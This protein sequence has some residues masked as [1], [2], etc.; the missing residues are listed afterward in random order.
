MLRFIHDISAA[1]IT[2]LDV[3]LADY[4][5]RARRPGL[6]LIVSDMFSYEGRYL[7][8]LNALLSRGHEV[9][10]AHV[11]APGGSAAA[12]ERRPQPD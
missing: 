9:A 2:D 8:G 5:L 1:G 10:F 4:A 6:T 11:L 12:G 3:A 7:D